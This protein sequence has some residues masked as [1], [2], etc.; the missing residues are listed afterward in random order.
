MTGI[1]KTQIDAMKVNLNA[2]LDKTSYGPPGATRY[3]NTLR[4]SLY[5]RI[6]IGFS[7][8]INKNTDK[9]SYS[10]NSIF[11]KIESLWIA[12]EV[13]IFR[14]FQTLLTI[15]DQR[16]VWRNIPFQVF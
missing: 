13:L 15:L 3:S 16:C 5:K 8:L 6:D 14:Y 4:T 1:L 2:Y 12:F 10:K 9:S 11:H 7:N